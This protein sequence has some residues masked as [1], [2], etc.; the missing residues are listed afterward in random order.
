MRPEPFFSCQVA[1]SWFLGFISVTFPGQYRQFEVENPTLKGGGRREQMA[2]RAE[3]DR[4]VMAPQ[5][6]V[7]GGT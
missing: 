5:P 7:K 1:N 3:I 6:G 2:R 4:H